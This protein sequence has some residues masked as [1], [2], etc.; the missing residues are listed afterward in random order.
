[1]GIFGWVGTRVPTNF[2][3]TPCPTTT[4]PPRS[5]DTFLVT[6]L[7]PTTTPPVGGQRL[8]VVGHRGGGTLPTWTK[9]HQV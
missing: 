2:L 6:T 3:L 5:E 8:L 9:Q 7:C 4:P 1:L